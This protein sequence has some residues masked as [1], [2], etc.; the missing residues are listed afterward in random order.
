MEIVGLKVEE[1][2]AVAK[3]NKY[4]VKLENVDNVE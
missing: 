1:S 2:F 4:E 3:Q